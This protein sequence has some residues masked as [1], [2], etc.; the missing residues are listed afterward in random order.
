MNRF[1]SLSPKKRSF[2]L[3]SVFIIFSLILFLLA[4]IA[5]RTRMYILHG[6]FWS[7]DVRSYDKETGLLLPKPNYDIGPIQT[8]SFGFRSPELESPKQDG[9]VRLAYMGGSTTFSTEVSS[10]DATWPAITTNTLQS[11]NPGTRFEYLNASAVAF[12]TRDSI[13]VF[14]HRVAEHNPDITFIYHSINDIVLDGYYAALSQGKIEEY[15]KEKALRNKALLETSLLVELVHK[16]LTIASKDTSSSNEIDGKIAYTDDIADSFRQRLTT[17]VEMSLDISQLV[18]IPTFTN[19]LR[20]GLSESQLEEAMV[21]HSFYVKYYGQEDLLNALKSYNDV[22]RE[23]AK[24]PRVIVV[25]AE[26]SVPSTSEYFADSVHFT[27]AGSKV[28]GE[29]VAKIVAN[30]SVFKDI[31][32]SYQSNN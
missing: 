6:S 23:F 19:M 27:D 3:T 10:N 32:T 5:V 8:N 17:L 26:H 20:D 28:F 2:L 18:I 11:T 7:L 15:N 4:E 24:N 22:I 25:E 30:N 12:H 16:N 21:T 31:L 14:K 29:H 13:G 1:E 9:T